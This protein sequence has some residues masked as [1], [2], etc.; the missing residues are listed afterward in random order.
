VSASPR[1]PRAAAAVRAR[2]LVDQSARDRIRGDLDG[3][4]VVEAAAGTGKTTALVG[5]I[6]AVLAQ[7]ARVDRIVA[8]TFT[9]K[10]AGE[11]KLRLRTE[12]EEARRSSEPGSAVRANLDHALAR[13][14]E[15]RVGTIHGFCADLLRERSVEAGVDPR[16]E[17]LTEPEA[18][19]L[20]R[21]SFDLW[22]Q[23]K[24]SD[25]PEGVRR[26]LRRSAR[27]GRRAGNGPVERLQSAGW[28]LL[29]W[30]DYPARW[31]RPA[32]DRD[33]A[34]AAL[35]GRLHAFAA[36]TERCAKPE[37]DGLYL[38]TE[39]ARRAA[40]EIRMAEEV[41]ER[42]PDGLEAALVDLAQN[43]G[44]TA[45]RKGYGKL[46]G[47]DLPR[48]D[49]KEAHAEL[50]AGLRDFRDRADA[51]LAACL[52]EEL[53][54]TIDRYEKAKDRA[55]RLDFLDLLVRA[56]D[57]VRGDA[58]VR[59]EFQR[60]FTHLF[61]DEFQDT[62]PLQAELL[63]LLAADDPEAVDW[64]RIAPSPGKLFLVADPKQSIYRFRRADVGVYH[65]VRDQLTTRGA[66]LLRLTTSFRSVPEIQAAVN[67]AFP[68]WM[69]GDEEA[70]QAEYVPLT[71]W[72]RDAE[73]QPAVIALPVPKPYGGRGKVAQYAVEASYPDA[74]GA[75][76]DWMLNESGWTVTTRE[77][78]EERQKVEE[79]HVC[80]LFRRFDSLF[81]GD[82]TRP[83]VEAMEARG[84]RHLLVGGRSFHD[85]EEVETLRTA[86]TAVEW[87]DDEL[88][89]FATLHG[90]LFAVGDEELL[91]YRHR[92]RRL[93]PF[94]IP[95]DVPERLAPLTEALRVL[96]KLHRQ[97]NRRPIAETV[98]RLLETTRAHAGFV[99][100]PSG[101]QAL[102]NV[103]HVAEQAR[104]Y[105]ITGG[106]SF[107][108]F[109]ERLADDAE[110]R[111]SQEAPILEEGSEGVRLMTVHK[112]KGLEFPV[113]VLADPTATLAFE[114]P[115][116]AID[117]R[118]GTCALRIAGWS[119]VDLNEEREREVARDVA[120]GIR[121]CYVAATRARDVLVIP[122][123]GDAP[124][125]D[126]RPEEPARAGWL[127]PLNAAVT[128]PRDRW[129]E[130]EPAPGTP[131]FGS[132]S[133]RDRPFDPGAGQVSVRPGL[134]R[135]EGS[136]VVW[137]DPHAL[138]LGAEPA[139]GIRQAELMD[140]ETPESVVADGVRAHAEWADARRELLRGAARPGLEVRT[141]T[142]W[143][144]AGR[145][146]G[147]EPEWIKLPRA[148]RRPAGPRFGAL[149][150]AALAV[151]PLDSDD[152]RVEQ[153]VELQARVLGALPDEAKA[154][155]KVVRAVLEQP[156]LARAREAAA[157][158]VCR[159]ETPVAATIDGLV[160]EGV[161]DLAFRENGAWTVIDFKTDQE[162][163]DRLDLYRRQVG[164]YA[165]VIARAT[166]EPARAV[167]M[168]I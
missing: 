25:P 102:A 104:A 111:K 152:A 96:A 37:K 161:V 59:A 26:S 163:E 155:A 70:Q 30:R 39:P 110:R 62:D 8:V 56:R 135:L 143:A 98:N 75:F 115:G 154:A 63:L 51:D 144:V 100:R 4:F 165:A 1:A 139:F 19:R 71:A 66:E 32:F 80:L 35:V 118:K 76:L 5:R 50:V 77:S 45:P 151:V 138:A 150:H 29:E 148:A 12:L 145:P 168:Q 164:L 93:H 146:D 134:H 79:R 17:V 36:L 40:R 81:A 3:T 64:T 6:V 13:L 49:V 157:R 48:D 113:V 46:F 58:A 130:A 85:R 94:R 15:A 141:A 43:R 38:D 116:R 57:L 41:R 133:V 86:L 132:D 167:L 126:L 89:V 162:I 16:F 137:W 20:Y 74:V 90:S 68:R 128:P 82:V 153:I 166:G 7:R 61:V 23:E 112:A 28:T 65:R 14:E 156:L 136:N 92:Y 131:K 125:L 97:R 88:S 99:L 129:G 87:P 122:A 44:F 127:S 24:L 83:Y 108:G 47:P 101:E 72:R 109:V 149:V 33:A 22:L 106:I 121:L 140:K 107:R 105:E 158:G 42:D 120:E 67:A 117:A 114:N 21:E 95:D 60:R 69:D 54:D 18:E 123:V 52:Q 142:E 34:I 53:R 91:E 73:A 119:P 147:P 160:V 27:F 55:G 9:E 103:L 11:M 159:R 10:A 84:I 124:L 2:E 31:R 78:G